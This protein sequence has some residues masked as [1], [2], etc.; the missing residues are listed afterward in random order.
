MDSPIQVLQ[1][2]LATWICLA[3]HRHYSRAAAESVDWRC[4]HCETP[5]LDS[6]GHRFEG[7]EAA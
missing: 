3:C 4:E 1:Q 2:E 7:K 5:L 6:R